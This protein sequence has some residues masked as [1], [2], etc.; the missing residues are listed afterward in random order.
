MLCEEEVGES[1][2]HHTP[3]LQPGHHASSSTGL[4]SLLSTNQDVD[5]ETQP[6]I[7]QV[8]GMTSTW[9]PCRCILTCPSHSFVF[10]Q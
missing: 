1:D 2:M 3:T 7:S 4:A 8:E 9:A 6:I 10:I 5:R